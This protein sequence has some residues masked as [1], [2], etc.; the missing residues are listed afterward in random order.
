RYRKLQQYLHAGDRPKQVFFLT[1]TP[2]NN[3][4]HDFRHIAELFTG[5][6]DRYF[7]ATLGIHSFRSH[8]IQLEK[9]ILQ[10]LPSVQQLDLLVEKEIQEAESALRTDRAFEALVVQRS[11][12]YVKES[13]LVEGDCNALFPE[14]ELPAVV[15][16]SVKSTYGALLE[17]VRKAF[18]KEKPL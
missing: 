6:D 5:G 7:A 18:H 2:V 16:Y 9:S 1:A 3:S 17:S 15:P 10:R 13:Q 11:R 8:F 4:V 14:R 12:A